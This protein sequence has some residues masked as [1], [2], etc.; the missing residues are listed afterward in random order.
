MKQGMLAVMT[1]LFAVAGSAQQGPPVTPAPD[2]MK[3]LAR[4]AGEWKGEGTFRSRT[5]E[6][7]FRQTESVRASINGHA[8][9]IEGLGIATE[10]TDVVHEA[11]AV[12]SWNR[13]EE[14]YDVHAWKADGS[15]VPATGR[16][17]GDRFVWGFEVPHGKVRFTIDLSDPDRWFEVGEFSMDGE[18]WMKTIEMNLGRVER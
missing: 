5:G 1:V 4:L 17:E 12:I 9:V 3:A 13:E 6:T 18:R 7:A 10:S 16:M 8:I 11:L 15:F 14:R 2:Q